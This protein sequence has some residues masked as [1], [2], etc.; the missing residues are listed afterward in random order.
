MNIKSLGRLVP[1]AA[2]ALVPII[3]AC[4]SGPARTA[5]GPSASP[6]VSTAESSRAPEPPVSASGTTRSQPITPRPRP[7]LGAVEHAINVS[8]AGPPRSDVCITVGGVL[9]L[10]N[11]GPEF[12]SVNP[13]HKVSCFYAAGVHVCRLVQTGSVGFTITNSTGTRLIRAEVVRATVPP[14]PST[15]CTADKLTIDVATAEMPWVAV[16][17]KVGS[18]VRVEN[19]GPDGFSVTPSGAVS[20]RYEAAVRECRLDR[21][22]TVTF[23]IARPG[24]EVRTLTVVVID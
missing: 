16:C 5:P 22:G 19:F 4:G 24:M 9:R 15:A 2:L 13:D 1:I 3:A 18:V 6:D 21:V 8:G 23:T 11:L 10:V 14:R 7:C 17:M 12:L 20:C